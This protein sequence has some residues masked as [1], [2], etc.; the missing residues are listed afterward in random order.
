MISLFEFYAERKVY[1]F[2]AY[3]SVIL[4]EKKGDTFSVCHQPKIKLDT[5]AGAITI[6]ENY[7]NGQVFVRCGK[8]YKKRKR[9]F[10]YGNQS[11]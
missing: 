2:P 11:F 1:G 3:Y 8:K 6:P 9:R 7:L 10:L 5:H 4:G